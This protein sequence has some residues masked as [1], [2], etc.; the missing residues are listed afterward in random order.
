MCPL[1]DPD[2]NSPTPERFADWYRRVL[3]DTEPR[4]IVYTFWGEDDEPLYVGSTGSLRRRLNDHYRKA[5]VR[6]EVLRCTVT[7]AMEKPEALR[8]ERSEIGR[9]RPKYNKGAPAEY[10]E[11]LCTQYESGESLASLA[12]RYEISRQRVHQLLQ[13]EGVKMIR[14]RQREKYDELLKMFVG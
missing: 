8:R 7:Q 11:A 10:V 9:L 12:A 5:W 3:P 1:T 14:E 4:F 13:A 6:A 2:S